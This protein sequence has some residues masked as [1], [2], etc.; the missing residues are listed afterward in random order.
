MLNLPSEVAL[1]AA[2]GTGGVQLAL[3]KLKTA[4][5]KLAYREKRAPVC[6][7]AQT[8]PLMTTQC[9]PLRIF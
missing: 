4:S 2:P 1:C 6:E 7:G 5:G 8:W 9:W 3:G